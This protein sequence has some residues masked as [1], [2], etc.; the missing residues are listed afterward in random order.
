M[1]IAGKYGNGNPGPDAKEV[2]A[3]LSLLLSC[4]LLFYVSDACGILRALS[5]ICLT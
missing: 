4:V 5:Q 3:E 2:V 1:G